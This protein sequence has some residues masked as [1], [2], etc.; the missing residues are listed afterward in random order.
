[1]P[2][3]MYDLDGQKPLAVVGVKG[4][5]R[6][7]RSQTG[8]YDSG[9]LCADCD[10]MIGRLDG[11]ACEKLV[12]KNLHIANAV[13]G[14]AIDINGEILCFSVSDADPELIAKFVLSVLWRCHHSV[15]EEANR[16]NLGNHEATFREV[17]LGATPVF[18]T[19]YSIHIEYNSDFQMVMILGR[20]RQ[21]GLNLNTFYSKKFGFHVKTDQ[22]P[23]E[24]HFK[25][26]CLAK[27][28]P[29]FAM[30]IK[31]LQTKFGRQVALGLKSNFSK[32]GTPWN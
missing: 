11:H 4:E 27:N 5:S 31:K 24:D 8:I 29:V 1:V 32:F 26:L 19:P 3:C 15:R 6:P 30:N 20:N 28:R 17:L 10:N 2:R 12:E 25:L 21:Q 23:H 7:K 14:K 16:V 22:K 13:G 9:I 18:N